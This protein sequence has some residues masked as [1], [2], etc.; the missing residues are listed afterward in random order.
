[1]GILNKHINKKSFPINDFLVDAN[2]K[3]I[4]G[5]ANPAK[6][7]FTPKVQREKYRNQQLLG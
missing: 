5:N 6:I 7:I 2:W 1:M 3:A 4:K